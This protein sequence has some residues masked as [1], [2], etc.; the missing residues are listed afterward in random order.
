MTARAVVWVTAAV[1]VLGRFA[2]LL[3]PLRP[4]EAGFLL[5]ARSWAPTADSLY[6]PYFVDRPPLMIA[7]VKL[8]DLVAGEYAVRVLAALGCGVAVLLT[9]AT[10]RELARHLS[11][12]ADED[13][14]RAKALGRVEMS[15]SILVATL[16]LTPYLDNVAAKGELLGVPLLLGS[17]LLAL[18]A[19]RLASVPLAL[20]AGLLAGAATGL[21]QALVGALAFGAVLLVV[22]LVRRTQP[23][24][25]LALLGLAALGGATTPILLTVLWAVSAGVDLSTLEYATLSF[26]SDASQVIMEGSNAANE[27]RARELF[28]RFFQCGLATVCIWGLASVPWSMRK[29]P[30]PVL[31][32]AAALV[33]DLAVV[34]LSGSFWSAYL[35]PVVPSA[36]LLWACTRVVA[37]TSAR[38]RRAR[39]ADVAAWAAVFHTAA[40]A[41]VPVLVWPFV[42][43]RDDAPPAPE[44]NGTAIAQAS[45]PGDTLVN[46]GGRPD[47]LLASGLKSPYPHLWSL[48]MRTMDPELSQLR[49]LLLSEDAPEWF[50]LSVGLDAWDGLGRKNIADVLEQRYR[51]VEGTC[52]KVTLLRR[53]DAP[54]PGPFEPDCTTPWGRR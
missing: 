22:A 26:R 14:A 42:V 32:A 28:N 12:E 13:P 39:T 6:G 29:L 54:A 8:A 27:T 43:W 10:V 30:A 35:F 21:K 40:V 31:A 47:L 33:V 50:A 2:G 18:R 51:V 44:V 38:T 15:S 37:T 1:A 53:V 11:P 9:A 4:D 19:L 23:R 3:W 45:L 49:T 46:Y 36:V 48:P 41:V 34:C 25:R 5:V 17:C 52:G 7:L 16:L 20:A 24:R